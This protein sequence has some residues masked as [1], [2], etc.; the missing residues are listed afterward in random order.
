MNSDTLANHKPFT[1]LDTSDRENSRVLTS[2]DHALS[3]VNVAPVRVLFAL[4][5]L[6]RVNRGAEVAFESIAN[7]LGQIPGFKVTVIGSGAPR[8]GKSYQFRHAGALPRERFRRFP[9]GPL[10]RHECMYE[11][12]S[13][14]P[15]LWRAYTPEEV[16]ITVTCSYPYMNW[17]LRARRSSNG[18]PLHVYVT[19]NGDWPIRSGNREYR[20][21]GC[22]GLV[23]TN[24]DYYE[25]YCER[26]PSVVIPNGVD[27]TLF[28]PRAVERSEFGLP[29]DALVVLMVSALIPSKR[30]IE[31]IRAVAQ[32]PNLFL[33]VA[34]E[35]P[36]QDEADTLGTKLL[37]RRYRRMTLKREEMPSLYCAC[38]V[39]L[40]M[41]KS[42]PSSVAYIE[43]LASGLPVVAHDWKVTRWT[44]EDRAVLVD[45]DV[46]TEVIRGLGEAFQMRT[47]QHVLARR[48]LI[49]R[50]FSWRSIAAEYGVFF[51]ELLCN[52]QAS[53]TPRC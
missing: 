7:E 42:E 2:G 3:G 5:G 37:G 50:R 24:S 41:S 18:R 16:D 14:V 30:V 21:F 8:E 1:C 38:D 23:C 15:G 29:A 27:P 6:H 4:P 49:L 19:Q 26:W 47:S 51:R 39:F 40:H 9:T 43:A 28:I 17:L 22:D 33:V 31:G 44:L 12:F 32:M 53:G 35:G 11:E 48:E 34:G 45:T 20:F 25:A 36:S 46:E 52:T 13:F 10:F